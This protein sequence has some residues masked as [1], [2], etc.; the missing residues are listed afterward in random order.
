MSSLQHRCQS[1]P[2]ESVYKNKPQS[3][4]PTSSDVATCW[5]VDLKTDSPAQP[6]HDEN[7]DEEGEEHESNKWPSASQDRLHEEEEE[8]DW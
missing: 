6:E 8:V 5:Q 2:K 4:P 3:S 1:I 7:N